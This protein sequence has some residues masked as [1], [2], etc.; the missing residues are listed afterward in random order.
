[1]VWSWV[2][3]LG[4]HARALEKAGEFEDMVIMVITFILCNL[5]IYMYV[6]NVYSVKRWRDFSSVTI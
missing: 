1:M 5:D 2:F 6:N 3:V 4:D